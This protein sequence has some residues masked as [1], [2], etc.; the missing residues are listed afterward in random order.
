MFHEKSVLNKIVK[1]LL[2]VKA[3]I[4]E[5]GGR[6]WGCPPPPNFKQKILQIMILQVPSQLAKFAP[7]F[8]PFSWT[9]KRK[10]FMAHWHKFSQASWQL[11]VFNMSF[12][13]FIGLSVH[14]LCPL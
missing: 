2:D 4:M 1:T 10:L 9:V 14:G 13:W 11:L 8:D 12:D 3:E 7:L 6:N 5:P